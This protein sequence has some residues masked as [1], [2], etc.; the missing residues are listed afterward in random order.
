[1]S[2]QD[3]WMLAAITFCVGTLYWLL[4]LSAELADAREDIA[5]LQEQRVEDNG[6]LVE[7]MDGALDFEH[8]AREAGDADLLRRLDE[9]T[10]TVTLV[11]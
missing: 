8:A 1:M 5:T 6:F 11:Q 2:A 10:Q 4:H 3:L 7:R 9:L